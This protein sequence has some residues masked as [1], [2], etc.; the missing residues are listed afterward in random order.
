[1]RDTFNRL[2]IVPFLIVGVG[3]LVLGLLATNHIVNNF[4][5][6]DVSRLDLVRATALDDVDAA[7]ILEAANGQ[8]LMAFLASVAVAVTGLV[9]PLV[10]YANVR[11]RDGLETPVLLVVVRQAMWVGMW[12]AFCLW[13]QMNRSLGIAVAALVAAVLG[14]F[15][16][17]LQVRD[18]ASSIE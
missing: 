8:I 17:L 16:V 9:M 10:Y 2:G 11:F 14:T 6:F 5:P 4:W 7:A 13:L 15:E 12:F 3:L 18:R 1:M